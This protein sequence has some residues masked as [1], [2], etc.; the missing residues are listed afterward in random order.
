MFLSQTEAYLTLEAFS[1]RFAEAAAVAAAA[2]APFA[3]PSLHSC[4]RYQP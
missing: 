3:I 2:A 4:S 1:L